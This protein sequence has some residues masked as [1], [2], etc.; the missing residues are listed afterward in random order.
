MNLIN[1][2]NRYSTFCFFVLLLFAACEPAI[3]DKPDIGA[4]P[5]ASFTITQGSTL[6]EFILTD[7]TDGAFMTNWIIEG[8]TSDNGKQVTIVIPF[9]GDYEVT[10]TS[11]N[12][13]GSDSAVQTITVTQDD[14]NACFGN[15]EMLTGGCASKTWK[16]APEEGA[17]R[18][19]PSLEDV[20]LWWSNSANDVIEREC[21]FNDT[22]TF[23][24][25]GTFIF[26]SK[27][28]F[29]ADFS[30]IGL[31]IACHPSSAWPEQ[32]Q[33]WDSGTHSFSIIGDKLT[34]SGLGAWIGL[35]K[36][37]DSGD[38]TT[39]E[40]SVTFNITSITDDRAILYVEYPN[41]TVWEVQLVKE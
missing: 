25:D 10:M 21:H 20:G 38:T 17:L 5:T 18:V 13:G 40:T 36:I 9:M 2:I 7:N 23:S 26:D 8:V 1:T 41:Q 12:R 28:D 11:F 37:S 6:N 29:W 30:E 31:D 22:Y 3:D 32:F 4:P 39:P 14:P 27:G 34:V 35:Y 19:G 16:I 33:V 15:F 24:S